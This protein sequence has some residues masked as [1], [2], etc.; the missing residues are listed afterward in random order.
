[1]AEPIPRKIGE[2]LRECIRSVT[3]LEILLELAREPSRSWDIHAL[4]RELRTSTQIVQTSLKDLEIHG[5]VSTPK[6]AQ[7][8]M[9]QLANPLLEETQKNLS[10]LSELYRTHRSR[11][12]E[13]IYASPL[14]QIQNLADA[15]RIKGEKGD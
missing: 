15:F 2:F 11:I 7:P 10:L 6:G 3:Q 13:A 1:M 8:P 4:S 14:E 9:F 5:L 12:I